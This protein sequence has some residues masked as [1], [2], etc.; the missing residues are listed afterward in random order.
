MRDPLVLMEL[1]LFHHFLREKCRKH[2]KTEDREKRLTTS[3]LILGLLPAY[4]RR[5]LP[6]LAHLWQHSL[7]LK[8]EQLQRLPR[9]SDAVQADGPTSDYW[10]L[11]DA[12]IP[13]AHFAA[14]IYLL[15]REKLEALAAGRAGHLQYRGES[16]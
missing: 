3:S 14:S 8:G 2:C 15:A 6:R 9:I 4:F 11:S 12:G 5:L 1:Y 7:L 13:L 10:L 16:L